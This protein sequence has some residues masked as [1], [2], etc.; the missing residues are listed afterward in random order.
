[1][2]IITQIGIFSSSIF[3]SSLAIYNFIPHIQP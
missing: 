1:M 3:C 2:S